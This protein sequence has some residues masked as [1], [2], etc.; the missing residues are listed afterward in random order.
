MVSHVLIRRGAVIDRNRDAGD[1]PW[2]SF[3]KTVLAPLRWLVLEA[4]AVGRPHNL[5][6][7]LQHRAVL[8]EHGRLPSYREAVARMDRLLTGDLLPRPLLS[9]M[10]DRYFAGGPIMGRLDRPTGAA[11]AFEAG[12]A[13]AVVEGTCV[14]LLRSDP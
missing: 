11:A 12:G 5:R 10:L 4:T 13:D 14:N 8:T 1:V 7:L 9:A 3:T 2:W 6:R